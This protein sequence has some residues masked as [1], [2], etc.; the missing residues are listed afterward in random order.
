MGVLDLH[1]PLYEAF[2]RDDQYGDL[3]KKEQPLAEKIRLVVLGLTLV[4]LR[5]LGCAYFVFAFYLT[6]R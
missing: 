4:P 6:C 2:S 1:D 5:V 3:G